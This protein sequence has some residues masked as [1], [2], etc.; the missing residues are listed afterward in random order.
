[1][2]SKYNIKSGKYIIKKENTETQDEYYQS[3][4]ESELDT[5]LS[6]QRPDQGTKQDNLTPE[7]I[8]HLIKDMIPLK[9]IKDKKVLTKLPLF[10]SWV[11]Y[12]DRSIKKFRTGGLLMKVEYPNYIVLSNASLKLSWSV[13]LTDNFLLFIHNPS[14]KIQEITVSA[15][16]EKLYELYQAGKIHIK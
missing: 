13:Q 12:Y 10:K 9:N 2:T 6:Y 14:E 8:K 7:N 4:S 16:K 1:M 11:K 15:K 5:G 3:D